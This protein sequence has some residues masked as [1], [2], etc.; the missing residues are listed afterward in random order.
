MEKAKFK[1]FGRDTEIGKATGI[2]YQII[3]DKFKNKEP[4]TIKA[5]L[6]DIINSS[7]K[8]KTESTGK[9]RLSKT[10]DAIGYAGIKSIQRDFDIRQIPNI[11][12]QGKN[13]TKP[14][15]TKKS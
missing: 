6:N 4:I 3:Q 11:G 15:F 13:K 14:E 9:E 12:R 8:G 10:F 5:S 2:N 1:L 7:K